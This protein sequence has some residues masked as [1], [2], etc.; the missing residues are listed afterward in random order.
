MP[1]IPLL[2]ATVGGAVAG[3]VG[4]SGQKTP[5]QTMAQFPP[6]LKALLQNMIQQ[7]GTLQPLKNSTNQMAFSM[8]PTW[9]RNTSMTPQAPGAMPGQPQTPAPVD[10]YATKLRRFLG[11]QGLRDGVSGGGL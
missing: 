2:V 6:E 11:N 3:K 5:T 10:D 1:I 9:A 4:G 7:Q 8:L